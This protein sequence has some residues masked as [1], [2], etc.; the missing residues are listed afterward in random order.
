MRRI[1][2]CLAALAALGAGL[3]SVPAAPAAQPSAD[4]TR[5]TITW[6]ACSTDVSLEGFECGTLT[7]P[8]DWDNLANPAN[9]SIELAVRRGTSRDRIGALTFNP[10]G[11]GESGLASAAGIH[12]VLP[13]KVRN[14]FDFVAW[15]PRGVGL[16]Q[17]QLQGCLDAE[18]VVRRLAE[19]RAD[20]TGPYT[21]PAVGPVDWMAFAQSQ[22][23]ALAAALP[24]CLEVNKDVAPYLGTYYVIRDLEAMRKALGERQWNFWGMS[25]GTRI[26]YRY[27]REFPNSFRTLLLDGSWSPNMT[28]TS[29][30][31]ASSWNFATAQAVFGSLFGKKM[32]STLQQVID[33]LDQR[34]ITV[35]GQVLTRWQILPQIFTNISNQS[36]FPDILD[37]IRMAYQGLYG[38]PTTRI[39]APLA[40]LKARADAN[41]NTG[42]NLYYINCRDLADY[43]TVEEIG[44]AAG[45]AAANN[46]V[47]AGSTAIIKGTLCAGLPQDF[48]HGYSPLT[49]PLQLPTPPV[50]I[51]SLGDTRT[52]YDF[53]R[54]MAN[55]LAGSSLVTYDSTQ[56]VSYRTV[57]SACISAAV[58]PY[59]LSQ[60]LPGTRLCPYAPIPSSDARTRAPSVG[61]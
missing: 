32:A 38:K 13:P 11:P 56:H 47:A 54:T 37:V 50:V 27:A 12:S 51:N 58:T 26:G 22:Y 41:P 20:D 7:V 60:T 5:G 3:S 36:A 49:K 2:V 8:L 15:D 19:P 46:S 10:G 34:T 55:Y 44:R 21:P 14:R 42:L 4:A 53:G 29:W 31:N 30:M 57:P 45:I 35:E 40:R 25:Y 43:P 61:R 9:A 59:F 33:G 6:H 39:L 17:P 24:A 1:L 23:T 18:K 16:T 52:E 28:V 48:T